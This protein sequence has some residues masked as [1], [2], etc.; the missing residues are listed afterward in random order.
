M[1]PL[2]CIE[3]SLL[4]RVGLHEPIEMLLIAPGAAVVVVA[5][6][7]GE[8]IDDNRILPAVQLHEQAG[9]FAAEEA[10]GAMNRLGQVQAATGSRESCGIVEAGLNRNDV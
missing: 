10:R 4:N 9:R 3:P 8:V 7:A 5:H 2:Q 6:A 1:A